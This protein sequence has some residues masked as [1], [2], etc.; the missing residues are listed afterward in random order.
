MSVTYRF[1]FS[2]NSSSLIPCKLNPYNLFPCLIY[3][4][5]MSRLIKNF[6]ISL[7]ILAAHSGPAVGE[8]EFLGWLEGAYLQ[9]WGIRVKA[10]LDSGA[11]TSALHAERIEPFDKEGQKWVRFHFPYGRR[12]GFRE[13]VDIEKPVVRESRVRIGSGNEFEER[14]VVEFDVCLSGKT[15]NIEVSLTERGDF[16]YPMLLG[17]E[18]MAG[19]YVIDPQQTF[20]GNRT[21]PRGRDKLRKKS[22]S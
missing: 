22:K 8:P 18:A 21:C 9:P 15:S 19:R 4:T 20:M 11:K 5:Q 12:D 7:A 14:Y 6:T 17:R 16:N 2:L 3:I 10:K 13:G 1:S